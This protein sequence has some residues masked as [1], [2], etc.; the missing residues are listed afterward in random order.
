MSERQTICVVDDDD[1]VR[2]M[3]CRQLQDAGFATVEASNGLEAIKVLKKT[4]VAVA[5]IDIIMPD[6][7]GLSTIGDVKR[8]WPNV[9]I[10]AISGGGTGTAAQYLSYA[11]DLGADEIM[12]KP[13]REHEF[14]A[15]VRRLAAAT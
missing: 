7:E 6:Q 9:P 14:L 11:R 4:R 10:L 1:D 3:M 15:H 2:T 5:V 12:T 13:F 8:Q